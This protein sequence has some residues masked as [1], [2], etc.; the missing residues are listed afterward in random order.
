ME[1]KELQQ[2]IA[3][4]YEKLPTEAQQVFSSMKW[5]EIL[6]TIC[7]KFKLNEEQTQ[8]LG[9]ETT[10]VL[11][12]IIHIEEYEFNLKNEIKISE[13]EINQLINEIKESVLKN[14]SSELNDAF[15]E[16]NK[17]IT[18]ISQKIDERF[19]KLPENT[20]RAIE[21]SNYQTK[22]Y[23]IGKKYNLTISQIGI[24]GES[25]INTMIGITHSD[26]FE[27]SLKDIQLSESKIKEIVSDVN[28][29]IFKQ[30]REELIK[31]T[32]TKLEENIP[33]ILDQKLSGTVQTQKTETEH[34]LTNMTKNDTNEKTTVDPYRMPIE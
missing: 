33:S 12:G 25:I 30:I 22:I 9:S 13:N 17:E 14:I 27:E 21:E 6:Q 19:E 26:K 1:Q 10:L 4:Y 31:S 15:N 16:N 23:E 11:L 8:I 32:E 24:L 29:E 20:K 34:S 7:E 28:T 3:E 18:E 2:K 5:L